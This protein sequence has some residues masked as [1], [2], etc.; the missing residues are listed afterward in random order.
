L[1]LILIL[2]LVVVPIQTPTEARDK[3]GQV[4]RPFSVSL[5]PLGDL[6]EAERDKAAALPAVDSAIDEF[7]WVLTVVDAA[8]D[9]G[10]Y[11]SLALDSVG[12]P[13]IS[14]Y[15]VSNEV[16]KYACLSGTLWLSET[17]SDSAAFGPY[18]S[19]DLDG[20]DRPHISCYNETDGDLLYVYKDGPSWQIETVDSAGDVGQYTSLA[21]DGEDLPH[22]AY[23]D[24]SGGDLRYA[25]YDGS[26]WNI[27]T[28]DSSGDVGQYAS[29]VLDDSGSGHISYYDQPHSDLLYAF[30]SGTVWITDTV[31]SS[32]NVGQ[33]TSLA[34]DASGLARIS[35]YDQDNGDLLYA[36]YNGLSWITETVDS[37]G[38]VGTHTSLAL[39]DTGLPRISY[40][41]SGN[42]DLKFA[43]FEDPDWITEPPVDVPSHVGTY[44]SLVLNAYGWPNIAYYS[45]GNANLKYALGLPPCGALES[46]EING[47]VF[48]LKEQVGVYTVTYSPPTATLPVT[49]LWDSGAVSSTAY[50]SWTDAGVHTITVSAANFC[51]EVFDTLAVTVCQPVEGVEVNGPAFLPIG[52]N[53]TYT[54]TVLPLTTTS[55]VTLTWSNGTVGPSA[56][57]S[58]TV[59][60][61]QTVAVTATNRCGGPVYGDM[62]VSVTVCQPVEGVEVDGPPV[63]PIGANG[64]YTAD[65]F[66]PTTSHP[67]TLTWSNGTVGPSAVY[68]WTITGTY[69]VAVTATNECGE[70]YGDMM[71]SVT[72][73]QP[74][75]A[76]EVDGPIILP[77]GKNGAYTATY[78]PP[79]ATTPLTLTWNNGTTG[80][81]AIYSWTVPGVQTITIS[82]A[83][84]CSQVTGT[85]TVTVCQPVEQVELNGPAYLAVNQIGVYTTAY[86]PITA[87]EPV[88]FSWS[89]GAVGPSAVFSWTVGGT[90]TVA[91]TATSACGQLSRSMSVLVPDPVYLP[92]VSRG[93]SRCFLDPHG[94]SEVEPNDFW[95]TDNGPLCPSQ[96]YQ[97]EPSDSNDFFFLYQISEMVTVT[98]WNYVPISGWLVLYDAEQNVCGADNDGEDGWQVIAPCPAGKNYVRI[99]TEADFT[100]VPYTFRANF[101]EP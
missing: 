98:M 21:L 46:A 99:I 31:D 96:E 45:F 90:Y 15:D 18:S 97:G 48:L 70:A 55:P 1:L 71:V 76:V 79:T 38:D 47:P 33:Y 28:V 11:A 22:I 23:Y 72:V 16:L 66:P 80:T 59:G 44:T 37:A 36:S 10:A 39:D 89:S 85:L 53:G 32:G 81:T 50:Y 52:A 42:T 94:Y 25:Y 29:L 62:M 3:V 78:F 49:F 58:W 64:T 8:G 84:L 54:A 35:Y 92:L 63:L 83:N 13:C 67:I 87:T 4:D 51:S 95:D 73:C 68:S 75:E 57:F 82:A 93:W 65:F 61:T 101:V 34:L 56:V 7:D 14:Y 100:T 88:S 20:E 69:T 27:Q 91:V 9:V 86:A 26:T 60:G 43:Y 74:V 6:A 30:Y 12:D 19:L 5:P 17:V 2:G 24:V 41:D 77:V 40:H